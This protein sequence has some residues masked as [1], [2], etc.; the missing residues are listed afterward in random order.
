[1]IRRPLTARRACNALGG[2]LLARLDSFA[3]RLACHER[4]LIGLSLM[5]LVIG[6][7]TVLYCLADYSNRQFL[8]GPHAYDSPSTAS[9]QIPHAG[10]SLYLLSD[11]PAWFEFLFHTTILTSAAFMIFGGRVLTLVQAVMM[12]SLHYRN[13][14]L[15]E[16]GDNLAQIL[17]IFLIFTVSDAYFAP[18]AKKR[19]ERLLAADRPPTVSTVLHNLAAF[20]IVFQTAVLYFAAG[21]WK[22]FGKVWQDG[23]AMYYISRETEFHM[24]A[25][26]AH[27]MGNA[28]LGTAVSYAT[29]LMEL[30]F[31]IALLSSR[32]WLR[33][34]NTLALEGMHLG[35]AAFMGLVCFGLLM[36]GADCV[37]LRD[38][39]YRSM[40]RRAR[41]GHARLATRRPPGTR[42]RQ[43]PPLTGSVAG[44][45]GSPLRK[46]VHDHV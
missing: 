7:A 13:Q 39:D 4:R 6:F 23:V 27:L 32:A 37:C 45:S 10:F 43:V 19:R 34:T 30:A 1:M 5:R 46:G 44:A 36:I 26:F 8:W 25:T 40:W 15:L 28:Y 16:G 17:V 29:V 3:L 2:F 9:A 35:I 33:K 14:D 11:S 12:W 38:D 22:I 21:Y 18:G 24:S 42:S 20:L 31:P 41:A